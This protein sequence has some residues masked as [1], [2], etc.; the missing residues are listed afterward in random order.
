MHPT[1]PVT[2]D[3]FDIIGK[4]VSPLHSGSTTPKF[5]ARIGK[6]F[7]LVKLSIN[8]GGGNNIL[9]GGLANPDQIYRITASGSGFSFD[10]RRINSSQ[11][12]VRL[13]S[14]KI[15][16]YPKARW[17]TSATKAGKLSGV[18]WLIRVGFGQ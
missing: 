16:V 1:A 8:R 15:S 6:F 4:I 5:S 13:S 17:L 9:G 7:S 3:M 18:M 11:A 14:R 2:S 12:G 10:S